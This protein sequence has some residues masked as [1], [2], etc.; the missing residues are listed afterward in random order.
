VFLAGACQGPKDIPA[1]VQQGSAAASK[2][3]ALFAK[4]TLK[5]S[6]QVAKVDPTACTG[7][8]TCSYVCHYSAID[9]K[10]FGGRQVAEVIAGKCQ[11]C[12]ACVA[13]CKNKAVALA[14]FSDDE[15]F[16]EMMR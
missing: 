1:S 13:T 9:Q 14:Q 2:V 10:E 5:K 8:L 4:E 7:C 11:G 12:G 16:E 6:P 3:L 15:V